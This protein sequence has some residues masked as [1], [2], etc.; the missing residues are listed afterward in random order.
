MRELAQT[1]ETIAE[2]QE[3]YNSLCIAEHALLEAEDE[4]RRSFTPELKERTSEI[5]S[6]LTNGKYKQLL[7]DKLYDIEVKSEETLGY[8][9]W[10]Y[11]SRG[12]CAQSYLALRIAVCEMLSDKESLPL[13]LD[14]ILSDYDEERASLAISFLKDYSKNGHQV[15]FFTCHNSPEIYDEVCHKHNI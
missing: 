6:L 13:L 10:H 9:K 1:Q 2:K 15:L 3:H 7:T 14:D 11:L 4:M 12:T 8:R 5:L